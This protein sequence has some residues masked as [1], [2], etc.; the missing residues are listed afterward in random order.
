MC[1]SCAQGLHTGL[2]RLLVT[3]ELHGV[4]DSCEQA[5]GCWELHLCPSSTASSLLSHLSN[6]RP[7]FFFGAGDHLCPN[8]PTIT[9]FCSPRLAFL[10]LQWSQPFWVLNNPFTPKTITIGVATKLILW[11]VVTTALG[12]VL[13]GCSITKAED[14]CLRL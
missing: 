1:I 10:N 7:G 5:C 14:C 12:T 11:L 13:E 4:T 9:T 8:L 2:K 3:M 6:P